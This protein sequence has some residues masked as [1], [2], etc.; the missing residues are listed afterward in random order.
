MSILKEV[1]LG[2]FS[3]KAGLILRNA[4]LVN[5]ILTNSEAWYGVNDKDLEKL[6]QV[7][8]YLL[9]KLLN[10]HS[11][12]AKETL[13]LETGTKP[14]RFI[15]KQ[16]R[17]MYLHHILTREE[18]ELIK[19]VYKSQLIKPTKNDWVNT[20]SNDKKEMGINLTDEQ[21]KSYSKKKFKKF[22][23]QKI[24]IECM[25]YLNNIKMR[26]KKVKNLNYNKFKIQEYLIDPS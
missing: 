3:I 26:H 11:K 5:G 2:K 13:Y 18:N 21:I 23:K 20:I 6:E 4:M 25:Q 9:R 14:L 16:R 7:D 22:V 1:P 17:L 10:A 12:T 15:I 19:R 24:D 8:E